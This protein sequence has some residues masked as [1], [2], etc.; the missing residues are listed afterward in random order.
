MEIADEIL[1]YKQLFDKGIITE[2][3]FAAKKAELLAAPPAAASPAP[4]P[5]GA[6]GDTGSMGWAVLGFIIPLVGLILY[7]VW[8]DTQPLNAA[9]AGK[10]ALIGAIVGVALG[11]LA[12]AVYGV[13]IALYL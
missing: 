5:A 13:L 9:K 11:I 12:G 6:P 3:E 4:S 10:G 1:K 2:A 8:K 7:L